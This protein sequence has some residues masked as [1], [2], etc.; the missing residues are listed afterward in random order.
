MAKS[1]WFY[2]RVTKAADVPTF[3][4]NEFIGHVFLVRKGGKYWRNEFECATNN[5]YIRKSDCERV[6]VAVVNLV[7]GR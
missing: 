7:Q 2:V 6:D 5:A 3:W 1:E 4:Y